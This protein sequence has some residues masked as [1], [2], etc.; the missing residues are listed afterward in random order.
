MRHHELLDFQKLCDDF[1]I[2]ADKHDKVKLS[3][4]EAQYK[5]IYEEVKEIKEKGID[6]NNVEEVLDGTID[7]LVTALGMLQKFLSYFNSFRDPM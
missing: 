6:Q 7:V 4:I 3:D 5:L 2:I 1:N